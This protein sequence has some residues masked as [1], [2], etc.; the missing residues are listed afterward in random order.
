MA[1]YELVEKTEINGEVWYL[2]RK[3]GYYVSDS[4]T[5]KLEQA[6]TMLSRLEQG[7][8]SEPI[9]KTLKTIEVDE[10]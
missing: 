1:K 8:P 3:D 10:D 5:R 7:T 9:F 2:I 6:E 4:V